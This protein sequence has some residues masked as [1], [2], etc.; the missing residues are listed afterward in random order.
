MLLAVSSSA[1]AQGG[2][3]SPKRLSTGM[4]VP[5][6]TVTLSTKIMG[7]VAQITRDEGETIKEGELLLSIE[8]AEW[9]ASLQ[10]VESM[11]TQARAEA[12]YKKK[13][14]A[15]MKTLFGQ[16][17]I[18]EDMVDQAALEAE[19]SDAKVRSAESAVQSARAML[20]ETRITVPFDAVLI[21]RS[22]E[23]GQLT[24]PGHP[25]FVVEDH[26]RLKFKT[27]VK[28]R[29]VPFVKA[30]Q[31]ARVTIDALGDTELKG[32]VS[33]IVPSGDQTTHSYVVEISLPPRKG[34]YPGMFGKAEFL[35]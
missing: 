27:S 21:T 3:V 7:R 35:E 18:S 24:A 13:L 28:E 15:K 4:V 12:A 30:G 1:F 29:D 5:N 23:V 22:A 16:K 17:S 20:S 8:D 2:E 31:K 14:E 9:R 32:T 6:R 33:K 26:S 25:L 34:L 19:V 10:S 11:L